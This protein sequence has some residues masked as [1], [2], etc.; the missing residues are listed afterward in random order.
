MTVFFADL[1]IV[2]DRPSSEDTHDVMYLVKRR[3]YELAFAVPHAPHALAHGAQPRLHVRVK[4]QCQT[5]GFTLVV[6]D[7]PQFYTDL[8][9]MMEYMQSE[10]RKLSTSA[11]LRAGHHQTHIQQAPVKPFHDDRYRRSGCS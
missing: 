6:E 9:Q 7:M 8:R 2:C 1:D 3:T 4:T 11:S 10:R 5:G